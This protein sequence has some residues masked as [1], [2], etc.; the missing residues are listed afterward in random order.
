LIK[1]VVGQVAVVEEPRERERGQISTPIDQLHSPLP[2]AVGNKS[3]YYLQIAR[4]TTRAQHTSVLEIS[5]TIVDRE[6]HIPVSP[7][8]FK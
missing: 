5:V 3:Q 4:C 2:R 8:K 6:N 7:R 1:E